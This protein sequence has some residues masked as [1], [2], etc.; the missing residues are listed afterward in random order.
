MEQ[1]SYYDSIEEDTHEYWMDWFYEY[2]CCDS[3]IL[4]RTLHPRNHQQYNGCKT[5]LDYGGFTSLTFNKDSHALLSNTGVVF[6]NVQSQH[7][8]GELDYLL[9]CDFGLPRVCK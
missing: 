4:L 8:L 2:S 7:K 9:S 6:T 3:V 5:S 1:G